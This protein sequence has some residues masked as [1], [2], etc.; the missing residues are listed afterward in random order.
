M[1]YFRRVGCGTRT[2]TTFCLYSTRNL[3]ISVCCLGL[4]KPRIQ[5]VPGFFAGVKRPEREV[6]HHLLPAA[7]L[8]MSGVILATDVHLRRGQGKLC[9]LNFV[10]L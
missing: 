10:R 9:A 4:T 1:Y 2:V 3:F 8:R 6:N 7:W 5:W